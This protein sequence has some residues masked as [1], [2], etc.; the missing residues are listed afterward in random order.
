MLPFWLGGGELEEVG[1]QAEAIV[2]TA[3]ATRPRSTHA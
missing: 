1:A 2:K 3:M